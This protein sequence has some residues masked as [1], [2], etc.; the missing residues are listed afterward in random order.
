MWLRGLQGLLEESNEDDTKMLTAWLWPSESAMGA[1]AKSESRESEE[2][3][4]EDSPKLL[5][6][7]R[8]ATTTPQQRKTPVTEPRSFT[9]PRQSE[10]QKADKLSEPAAPT[11]PDIRGQA[12][13]SSGNIEC[14]VVAST[15]RQ[16]DT[17]MLALS[18]SS[19]SFSNTQ[20]V[21]H[22]GALGDRI[23]PR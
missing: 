4:E 23:A 3:G 12:G 15:A 22:D 1:D 6:V 13:S 21:R 8:A 16:V 9:T 2:G 7:A 20:Q 19:S 18:D 14:E 11:T 17:V 10:S 5:E